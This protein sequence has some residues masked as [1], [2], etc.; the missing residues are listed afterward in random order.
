M[1]TAKANDHR[2]HVYENENKYG[3]RITSLQFSG[4]QG[5]GRGEIN[6]SGG[7]TALCGANGVGKSTLLHAILKLVSNPDSIDNKNHIIKLIGSS[8][9]GNIKVGT[10]SLSRTV[11]ITTEKI[12]AD[13][14]E[15]DDLNVGW[16]DVA[17]QAPNMVTVFSNMTYIDEMLEAVGSRKANDEEL[18]LLSYIIG[19]KYTLVETYELELAEQGVLPYFRVSSNGVT[20]SSETM[21]LGELSV[22][23]IFWHLTTMPKNSILLIEEPETYLTPRSQEALLDVLFKI[24]DE[25]RVWIILSTH[26]PNIIKRIPNKHIRVLNRVNDEVEIIVPED[27]SDH[28]RI[29]GIMPRK[30]GIILVEDRAAREYANCW[31]GYFMPNLL[32]EYEIIDVKS[33]ENIISILTNFPKTGPWFKIIGLL[34]GDQR[35]KVNGNSFNWGYSFL[36]SSKAP[37]QYLMEIAYSN[38]EE[39]AIRLGRKVDIINTTFSALEG[40][41]HHDWLIEFP[42]MVG[43]TYEHLIATIFHLGMHHPTYMTECEE[44]FIKFRDLLT[45]F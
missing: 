1:R 27:Q 5:I 33:K 45:G 37:E 44:A 16:I 11:N 25:K 22:H 42:R 24:S 4:L 8:L 18:G 35:G 30:Q 39:L 9:T 43:V 34:D 6:F 26:S 15:I 23:Y 13:P 2:R 40:A 10:N 41:D 19:K 7:V 38:R 12:V 32:S 17:F 14:E 20:Y 28:L 3:K 21:G 29:L 31:I 36:P